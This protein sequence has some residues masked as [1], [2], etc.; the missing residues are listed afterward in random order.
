M[1]RRR[2]EILRWLLQVGVRLAVGAACRC[3]RDLEL[4]TRERPSAR[5]T[6]AIAPLGGERQRV[7]CATQIVAKQVTQRVV[8]GARGGVGLRVGRLELGDGQQQRDMF[9][10]QTAERQTQR[11]ASLADQTNSWPARNPATG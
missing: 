8:D 1:R 2:S 7:L 10:L 9:A 6:S 4:A 3:R 5:F 11:R